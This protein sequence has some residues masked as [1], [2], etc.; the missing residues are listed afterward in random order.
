MARGAGH[1]G[2]GGPTDTLI[3]DR[4]G[5]LLLGMAVADDWSTATKVALCVGD[6]AA[7]G[8]DLT[9]SGA[10]GLLRRNLR[11]LRLESPASGGALDSIDDILA[12]AAMVALAHLHDTREKRADAARAVIAMVD[13]H[14]V[15]DDD[16]LRWVELVAET[17]RSGAVPDGSILSGAAAA[18]AGAGAGAGARA[19]VGAGAGAGAGARAGAGATAETVEAAVQAVRA[20]ERTNGA[21]SARFT[22]GLA[23]ATLASATR[24][25]AATGA[26]LGARF[27]WQAV[28]REL[29]DHVSGWP[30]AGATAL[31]GLGILAARSQVAPAAPAAGREARTGGVVPVELWSAWVQSAASES[32]GSESASASIW[33]RAQVV[34]TTSDADTATS[35]GANDRRSGA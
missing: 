2:E 7:T 25:S 13:E 5:G 17:V 23:P 6:A 16:V 14:T 11:E 19:G 21:D 32:A 22:A 15:V 27:G 9:D 31:V 30:G 28:P 26:L 29:A 8:L 12:A 10:L 18:G 3:N 33:R 1:S 4:A 24:A 35:G 34:L 20:G